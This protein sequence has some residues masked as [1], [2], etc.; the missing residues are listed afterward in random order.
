M[1]CSRC[2]TAMRWLRSQNDELADTWYQFYGIATPATL[3]QLA[4][5]LGVTLE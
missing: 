1:A 2:A 4:A 5:E 3:Q